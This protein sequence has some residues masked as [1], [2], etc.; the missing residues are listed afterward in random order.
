MIHPRRRIGLLLAAAACA[1][2]L[3]T[4]HADAFP[5]KPITLVVPFAQMAGVDMVNVPYKSNPMA[6]TDLM[7]GQ[8]D[9]MFADAPTALPQVEGGKLRALAVSGPKEALS[10][11]EQLAQFQAS[12]SGKWGR[13][14]KAA[15]IQPE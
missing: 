1:L 10:T 13:V 9:F 15:G 11:P 6:I 3:P 14:I 8:V 5:S 4:A 12:E 7:G 2:G